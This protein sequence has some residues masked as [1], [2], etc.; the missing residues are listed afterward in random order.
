MKIAEFK[1]GHDST[2]LCTEATGNLMTDT[3]VQLTEYAEV[4][5]IPLP[6]NQVVEGQ[7]KQIDTAEKLLRERFQEH[8][9]EL[10]EA[11]SKLLSLTH[12]PEPV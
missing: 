8:L 12:Q 5:L 6:V 11:R 4:T 9:N 1:T 10:T 7:L 2:T 3:W